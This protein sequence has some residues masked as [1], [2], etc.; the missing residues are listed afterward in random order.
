VP[1]IVHL[2]VKATAVYDDVHL[3]MVG[4]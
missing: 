4:P 3:G 1:G 2:D